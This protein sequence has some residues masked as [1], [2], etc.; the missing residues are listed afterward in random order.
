MSKLE[1]NMEKFKTIWRLLISLLLV[2]V[3]WIFAKDGVKY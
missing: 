3:V 1:I 2:K